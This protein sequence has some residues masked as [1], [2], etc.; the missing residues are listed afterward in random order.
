M[1]KKTLMASRTVDDDEEALFRSLEDEDD[2]FSS[3]FRE[4]RASQLTDALV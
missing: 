2:E 1:A 3:Q 4:K